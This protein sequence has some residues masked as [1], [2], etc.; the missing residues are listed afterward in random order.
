MKETLSTQMVMACFRH[1]YN[2]A[3]GAWFCMH[4]CIHRKLKS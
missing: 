1:N 2:V 4:S 3:L